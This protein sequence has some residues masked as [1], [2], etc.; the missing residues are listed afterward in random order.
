M[1]SR[2]PLEKVAERTRLETALKSKGG[3]LK[4]VAYIMAGHPSAKRSIDVGKRLAASGVAAIEIAAG[5]RREARVG[6]RG[7]GV[8][9]RSVL[10]T[11]DS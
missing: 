9:G 8:G 10:L 7:S 6:G 5:S 4:L 3:D 11:P 1:T 2:G